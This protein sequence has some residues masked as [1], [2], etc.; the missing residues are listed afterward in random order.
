M[1]VGE[2]EG[3]G[4]RSGGPHLPQEH[5]ILPLLP[6]PDPSFPLACLIERPAVTVK[7]FFLFL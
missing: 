4:K 3:G 6:P 7:G 2:R 5:H 1:M